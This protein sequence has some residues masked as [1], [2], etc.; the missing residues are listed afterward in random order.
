MLVVVAA[1]AVKM[2][3]SSSAYLSMRDSNKIAKCISCD[4]RISAL[5]AALPAHVISTPSVDVAEQLSLE[6][7]KST[8][9]AVTFISLA[10]N[11]PRLFILTSS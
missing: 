1:R 8:L 6:H 7:W 10:Q 5:M 9:G 2:G 3:L 11:L 4:G